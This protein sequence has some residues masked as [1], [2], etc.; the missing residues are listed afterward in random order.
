[1]LKKIF[2]GS[3]PL[4]SIA[5][6]ILAGLYAAKIALAA[7][8]KHWYEVAFPVGIAILGRVAGDTQNTK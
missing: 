5:G 1:M 8:P 3:N 4:T 7:N 6:Y 2:L